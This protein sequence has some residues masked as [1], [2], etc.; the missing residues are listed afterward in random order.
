MKKLILILMIKVH[1][2]QN[3]QGVFLGIEQIQRISDFENHNS[4]R[5]KIDTLMALSLAPI[6]AP[7]RPIIAG[8]DW[9][10]VL[11]SSKIS[12]FYKEL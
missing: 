9:G 1:Y 12:G 8:S 7:R 10:G 3:S 2:I 4:W 5:G 6:A 11:L